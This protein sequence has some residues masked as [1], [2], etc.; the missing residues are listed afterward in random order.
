MLGRTPTAGFILLHP[1]VHFKSIKG[2]ALPTN[3]NLSQSGA[4]LPTK[5]VAVHAQIGGRVA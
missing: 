3:R 4:N 5:A 2:D 1:G